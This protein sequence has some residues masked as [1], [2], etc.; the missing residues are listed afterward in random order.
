MRV[1]PS[2][3]FSLPLSLLL[4]SISLPFSLSSYVSLSPSL[5]P[6]LFLSLA[7]SPFL[8]PSYSH[9]FYLL[10]ISPPFSLSFT[11]LSPSFSLSITFFL[12]FSLSLSLTHSLFFLLSACVCLHSVYRTLKHFSFCHIYHFFCSYIFYWSLFSGLIGVYYVIL[13]LYLLAEYRA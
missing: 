10:L 4:I 9:C 3:Y 5:S 2:I 6:F 7:M 8:P 12:S 11:D 13:H 1:L